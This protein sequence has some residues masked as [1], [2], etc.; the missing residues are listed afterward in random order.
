MDPRDQWRGA[1][2]IFGQVL[3][4]MDDGQLDDPTPCAEWPVRSLIGHVASGHLVRVP[5]LQ[6]QEWQGSGAPAAITSDRYAELAGDDPR[7]TVTS[8]LAAMGEVVDGIEDIHGPAGHHTGMKTVE[9][10]LGHLAW[11]LLVH[12]WDLA[13]GTGQDIDPPDELA[14]AAID[15]SGGYFESVLR[16][17][18]F[19]AT[20]VDV[21]DG[22]STMDRL[23]ALCG[24]TP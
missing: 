2:E 11:D 3:D 16:P 8:A 24:R 23:L 19:L 15:F 7:A 1:A 10:V 6:G 14:Q 17:N 5:S 4:G 9:F 12:A 18:G 13:R 21:A 20:E 22:S